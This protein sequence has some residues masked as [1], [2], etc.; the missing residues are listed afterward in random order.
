MSRFAL[1]G[2]PFVPAKSCD[3]RQMVRSDSRKATPDQFG[4]LYPQRPFEVDMIEMHE[5]QQSWIAAAFPHM[6]L[7]IEAFKSVR[8]HAGGQSFDPFIEVPD[9]Y[10]RT[11]DAFMNLLGCE[12]AFDLMPKCFQAWLMSA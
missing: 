8:Q 11:R 9:Q 3:K 6:Q 1:R 12:E 5:R 4:P 2:L 7:E 10:A